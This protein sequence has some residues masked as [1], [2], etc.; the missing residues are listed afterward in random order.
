MTDHRYKQVAKPRKPR[1][2]TPPRG[3]HPAALVRERGDNWR[4]GFPSQ[5]CKVGYVSAATIVA[6]RDETFDQHDAFQMVLMERGVIPR[7]EFIGDLED[8]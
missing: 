5:P 6:L 7:C 1:E 3:Y 2:P 8:A 4:Q